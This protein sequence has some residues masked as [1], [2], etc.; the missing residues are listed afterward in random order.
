M[1][2]VCSPIQQ[3]LHAFVSHANSNIALRMKHGA[4]TTSFMTMIHIMRPDMRIQWI[5]TSGAATTLQ[6]DQSFNVPTVNAIL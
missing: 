4:D 3:P 1:H 2:Y 6:L 5:P